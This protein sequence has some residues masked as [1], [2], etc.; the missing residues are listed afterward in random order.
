MLQ[1]Y[2]R[3]KEGVLA[4]SVIINQAAMEETKSIMQD[5]FPMMVEYFLEDAKM[6]VSSI[7]EGIKSNDVKQ[8]VSPAHTIKSSAFQ[9]GAQKVSE[10]AKEIEEVASEMLEKDEYDL[11]K[12]N[13]LYNQ[14][15]SALSEAE[16]ELKKCV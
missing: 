4:V 3:D 1:M 8:V 14:L 5:K 15:D 12:L 13:E 7:D 9:V 10:I 11:E 2:V 6:Y 16:P